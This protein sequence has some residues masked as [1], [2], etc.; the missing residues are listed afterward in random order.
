MADTITLV[1]YFSVTVPNKTGEGAKVLGALKDAGI[2]LIGLWGYPVKGKKAQLDVVPV[3]PKA[4][5]KA[6]RKLK[7]EVGA[8]QTAIAWGGEDRLGAV[9]DAAAKLAAAGIG[10]LA[11]QVICSG[12]GR[13]GG[14]IQVAAADLKKAAKILS[15]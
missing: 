6:A 11:T 9:A 4:F 12:E 8:K 5:S 14:L 13:F 3:D 2:S 1:S 15:A 7:L 10:I